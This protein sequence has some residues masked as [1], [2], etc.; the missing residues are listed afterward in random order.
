MNIR[1]ADK[2]FNFILD[3]Y[4]INCIEDSYSEKHRHYHNWDHISYLLENI[5]LID[6]GV[7][8]SAFALAAVFHDLAYHPNPVPPGYNEAMSIHYLSNFRLNISTM[9]QRAAIEMINATA[10]H[11]VDQ[12]NLSLLA[13]KFLDLDLL[14][15]ANPDEERYKKDTE[16]VEKE[17]FEIYKDYPVEEVL[18]GR[19]GFLSG[20]LFN[21]KRIYYTL[22]EEYED[23]ARARIEDQFWSLYNRLKEYE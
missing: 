23:L 12:P 14:G 4:Y 3:A 1:E 9:V 13:Q 5:S 7:Y 15:F 10:W 8:K 18:R 22:P 19:K 21:R 17:I 16:N 2:K 20:L 11:H 6:P